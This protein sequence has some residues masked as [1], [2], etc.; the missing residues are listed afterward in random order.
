M[1]QLTTVLPLVRP[2]IS[3]SRRRLAESISTSTVVPTA[4]SCSRV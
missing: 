3:E 1:T 4:R 2:D